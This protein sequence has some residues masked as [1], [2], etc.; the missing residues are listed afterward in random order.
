MLFVSTGR[1]GTTRIAQILRQSLPANY[2]VVHQVRFARLANIAGNLLYYLGG[3]EAVKRA[4][5]SLVT[6]RYA[7]GRPFIT[8]DPLTAMIIPEDFVASPDVCIVHV[9][10]EPDSFAKSF[11]D[12]S[13]MRFK[14]FVAHAL[15]PMWQP[16]IWP[17]E[18]LSRGRVLE[19]YKRVA[20]LKKEFFETRYAR[21]PNY[22]SFKMKDLFTSDALEKVVNG[23]FSE[24]I[25]IPEG[26]L[27]RKANQTSD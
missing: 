10:R 8:T 15:V 5:F 24:S 19:K 22:V 16:G 3:G 17:L 27:S 14:S 20:A 18:N 23:F 26:E 21:N 13:R 25:R 2:A 12:L 9:M 7:Q 4:L 6:D 1:C 11:F